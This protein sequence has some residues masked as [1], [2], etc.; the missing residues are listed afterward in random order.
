MATISMD[1]R[2][3]FANRVCRKFDKFWQWKLPCPVDPFEDIYRQAW[4]EE[5]WS[6]MNWLR[7]RKPNTFKADTSFNMYWATDHYV[8][9]T[10]PPGV[11]L[12]NFGVQ[13]DNLPDPVQ[14]K[15]RS[16]VCTVNRFRMLREEL[17]RR[18]SGVMGNPNGEGN[19][20][21]QRRYRDLDPRVNTPKQLY[22][23]WPEIQ[24]VM[25]P[26]WKREVQLAS[27]RSP[28]PKHVGYRM[29]R[30][31]Y[32]QFVTPEQFRCEDKDATKYE[33]QSFAELNQVFLL[34]SF[35]GDVPHVDNYPTFCGDVTML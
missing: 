11:R 15:V 2:K 5:E 6:W 17:K 1:D 8:R 32:N 25:L 22:R 30:D 18:V 24:P 12:P 13:L 23:L 27:V 16:W 21:Q 19:F 35:A 31:G 4:T 3:G 26:A 7:E 9:F 29:Y 34:V 28:L 10:F 14:R 33:K 20:C